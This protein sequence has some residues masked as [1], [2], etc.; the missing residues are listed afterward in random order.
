MTMVRTSCLIWPR[1]TPS[2]AITI[3]NSLTW[4]RLIAGMMLVR[5]PSRRAYRIGTTTRRLAMTKT[6]AASAISSAPR[7]GIWICIPRATKKSVTKKSRMLTA[8]ATT[9]RL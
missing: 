6:D 8:L 9:S 4:A 7:L 2:E 3:E 5:R 1:V